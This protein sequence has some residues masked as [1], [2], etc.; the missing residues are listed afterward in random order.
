MKNESGIYPTADR[1]LLQE[2]ETE[3]VSSGG[4]VLAQTTTEKQEMAEIHA[5]FVTGGEVAL[6][7]QELH[8][9]RPGDYVLMTKYAGIRYRGRDGVMYRIVNARDVVAKADGIFE[10]DRS[11]QSPLTNRA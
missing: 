7:M 8:G 4:I 5:K 11:K 9:I 3:K 6:G 2:V 1:V 10:Q